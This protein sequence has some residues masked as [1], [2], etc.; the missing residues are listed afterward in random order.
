M[1]NYK[2]S[3]R[4]WACGASALHLKTKIEV[5]RGL[6]DGRAHYLTAYQT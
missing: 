1:L 6:M 3:K 2:R 4:T 5:A